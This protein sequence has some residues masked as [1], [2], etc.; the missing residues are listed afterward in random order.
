[1][2]DFIERLERMFAAGELAQAAALI[3]SYEP[4]DAV[5]HALGMAA[6]AAHDKDAAGCTRHAER[7]HALR[8]HDPMTLQYM[9]VAALL[10]GDR[11]A[12]ETHARAAV[13]RGGG[14]RSLGWL[15]NIQL[16]A[17]DVAAAEQTYRR[18]LELSPGHVQALNGLGTC[19]YKQ[20]DLDQAT[21][22]LARA[23]DQDPTD[24]APIRSLMNMYGD[25][26]RVL[27]A[28]A[29]A[30]L[31]RD[32]HADDESGLALD[33]M[34]LHLNQVLMGGY[35]P[36][37]AVPDADAAVAA[38]VRRAG[39]R[40]VRV[41]LGVARALIDCRRHDEAA[42]L[43]APLVARLDGADLST[44]DRGNAEYVRG[45]LAQHAGDAARALAAYD[46]ALAIDPRRWDACCNALT[47]LLDRGDPDAL[48]RAAALLGRVPPE[49]K[50]S[51]PQLL[52]NEAVYL[53]RTGR[54][55][56]ARANL[57][58]VVAAT[59]GDGELGALARQLMTEVSDG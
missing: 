58:R 3:A 5:R 54:A 57:Q 35:P 49:V 17:G 4:T 44:V 39:H 42:R 27:G 1:M 8:P 25:A 33:L 28:L 31:V 24:P 40:P 51:S 48:A 56:D 21:T 2:E 29:L 32:R 16:G 9:A 13:E 46:A 7:A 47:L 26:G 12:A 30:G 45:L 10:R 6:L 50:G 20:Q 19:R 59:H 36:P 14:L 22:Y 37:N 23:F 18:M 34:V 55:A 43:I 15:G 41:Q 38:V 11:K 53:R 52:F